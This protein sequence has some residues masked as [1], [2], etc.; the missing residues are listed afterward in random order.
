ML[1]LDLYYG[2]LKFSQELKKLIDINRLAH[3][4]ASKYLSIPSFDDL[5][6][7]VDET[8]ELN[9]FAGRILSHAFAEIMKDVIPNFCYDSAKSIFK[10]SSVFYATPIERSKNPKL[11]LMYLY[12]TKGIGVAYATYFQYYREYL[13]A[14]H[15]NALSQLVGF[16]GVSVLLKQIALNFPSFV[17]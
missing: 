8:L 1:R 2:K 12:G 3:D 5:L 4:L 11:R 15:F 9:A 10:R 16:S 13:G 14:E 17:L 6:R 7:E